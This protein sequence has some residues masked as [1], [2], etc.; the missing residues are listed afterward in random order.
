MLYYYSWVCDNQEGLGSSYTNQPTTYETSR[1]DLLS[2]PHV[3]TK[4]SKPCLSIFR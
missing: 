4:V 2:G 3:P 1:P